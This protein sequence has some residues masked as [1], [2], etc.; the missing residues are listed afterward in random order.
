M[1]EGQAIAGLYGIT[2]STLL[3]GDALLRQSE[4]ALRAGLGIL[5]YRDKG[6][7]ARRR[8]REATALYALCREYGAL[9][10]VNDDAELAARIRAPALHVGRDD[11]PLAELRRHFGSSLCIGVSCYDDLGRAERAQAEGADYV[12]FGAFFPSASKPDACRAPLSLLREARRRLR[13][14][15]VAIG[16]IDAD[17]GGALISAGADA[18]AVISALFGAKD[19]AA[20]TRQ[21]QALFVASHGSPTS[22]ES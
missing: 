6:G 1:S 15:I 9:F 7:D 12:A 16:G 17:N 14:P 4:I 8:T 13:L 2:D 19:V 3:P 11:A 20:A 21:L 18:L 5:Q 10:V 22:E